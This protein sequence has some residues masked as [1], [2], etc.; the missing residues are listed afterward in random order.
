MTRWTVN[1]EMALVVC[2]KDAQNDQ[3][4]QRQPRRGS[5]GSGGRQTSFWDR[6]LANFKQQVSESD[7]TIES[8]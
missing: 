4:L 3:S 5:G 1:E 7:R 6:V 2:V 8:L